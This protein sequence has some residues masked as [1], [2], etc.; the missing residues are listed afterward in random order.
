[1]TLTAL[2]FLFFISISGKFYQKP[3]LPLWLL[4]PLRHWLS[5]PLPH[6]LSL[7]LPR[8]EGARGMPTLPPWTVLWQTCNSWALRCSPMSCW[9]ITFALSPFQF[10][11]SPLCL[12]V[13]RHTVLL[14]LM[15]IIQTVHLTSCLWP[16]QEVVMKIVLLWNCFSSFLKIK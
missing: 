12:R 9:V 13:E 7:H 15:D 1:M 3:S 14:S 11:T 2:G 16:R 8:T 10:K 6:R 4:L 5:T